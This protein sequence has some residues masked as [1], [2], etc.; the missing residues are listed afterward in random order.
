MEDSIRKACK[1]FGNILH[2]FLNNQDTNGMVYIRFDNTIGSQN[3]AQRL[4]SLRGTWS[5]ASSKLPLPQVTYESDAQYLS[6]FN[7]K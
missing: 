6:M 4:P 3:A 2:I 1:S 7:L 5:A